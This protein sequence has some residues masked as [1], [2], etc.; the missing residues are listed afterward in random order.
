MQTKNVIEVISNKYQ[1]DDIPHTPGRRLVCFQ[2]IARFTLF[3]VWVQA[4]QDSRLVVVQ[5][6]ECTR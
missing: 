1:G 6:D 3:S 5:L 2:I 4:L